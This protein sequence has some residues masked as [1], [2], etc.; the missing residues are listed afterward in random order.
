VE[1][2]R[3]HGTVKVMKV[4]QCLNV[5]T[6]LGQG[7]W[8]GVPLATVLRECGG[9]A[10]CR[11]IFYWGYHNNDERQIFRSSV[12]YTE[13]FEPV[14]GE[15]PV[16]LAFRLNGQPIPLIRGGPVRMI[17]P[18]GH[19]FK[20]VKF[21]QAIRLTNDYRANDTYAAIDEGDEGN[22]PGSVQKTYTTV[23]T[24]HGAAPTPS[25]NP[26][27][28]SGVLMN[29]RT[30]ASHLEY[31]VRGPDPKLSKPDASNTLR[32]GDAELLAGPWVRF[33]IPSPPV[34]FD[35]ALFGVRQDGVPKKWPLPFSF[36]S[37]TVN[38]P[39]LRAG[40][41]ELRARTVDE[42]GN[43]QPEP[44]RLQNNGRNTIGVRRVQVL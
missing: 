20:S 39:G 22:D 11:R 1:L 27:N 14:P 23:D 37:W 34:P 19:G 32:D 30:P 15:P 38:I 29:G 13:A 25:G 40:F 35:C 4:M 31:W 33:E 41:Y 12:S 10:N 44:R 21:L 42:A 6:P 24:S 8:E 43:A 36:T 18:W 2:G 28:L 3:K 16:F 26:V 5:D 17:V 7:V 9:I